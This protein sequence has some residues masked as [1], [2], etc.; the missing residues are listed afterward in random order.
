MAAADGTPLSVLVATPAPE[1]AAAA[2]ELPLVLAVHGFA[3]SAASG[4][5]RTGHLDALT[6]AGRTVVA[7]DLRG[8]GESGKPHDPD[9]YTL[10]L[11][12]GD[13][14]RA[15][16]AAA[17]RLSASPRADSDPEMTTSRGGTLPRDVPGPV[18]FLGYSLGARLGW[19]L[20]SRRLLPIRRMVLGG[21]DGR[22]L[23]EGAEGGRLD[24]IA[25]RV[26]GSDRVALRHL[27]RGLTRSG[28]PTGDM[29]VPEAPI[30]V[31]AGDADDLASRAAAF[32]AT[33]P[34]G[35]FLPVPGRDHIS[36][37]PAQVFR[38][39]AVAFLGD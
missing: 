15:F 24:A 6:R 34:H 11:V 5:G 28:R 38:R 33:L 18:D 16:A 29:Q 25:R 17:A 19:T 23:F 20:A 35:T 36:A 1:D 14:C 21:F 22:P 39:G 3:S 37:A 9:A 31:V 10:D 26:D 12:L 8:H 32:V 2:A 27:V 7:P 30:L 13:L 4:W